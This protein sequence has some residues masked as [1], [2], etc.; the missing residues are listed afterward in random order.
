MNLP[1]FLH[2]DDGG[3][4]HLRGH[5]VGLH[6]VVRLYHEGWSAEMLA[7][8]Y[9]TVPL[10]LIHKVIAFYLDNTADVDGYVAEQDREID[11]QVAAA[12]PSP[13]LSELRKRLDAM[14]RAEA[15]S[16]ASAP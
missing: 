12:P 15:L 5:R 10:S 13:P 4:V 3:F 9:P 6:H 14:R 7:L 16:R 8:E 11:R 2:A 1:D